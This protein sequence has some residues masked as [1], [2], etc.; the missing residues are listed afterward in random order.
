[1]IVIPLGIIKTMSIA[2]SA[3]LCRCEGHFQQRLLNILNNLQAERDRKSV[4]E[5]KKSI[6]PTELLDHYTDNSWSQH[7]YNRSLHTGW[8]IASTQTHSWLKKHLIPAGRLLSISRLLKVL[9]NRPDVSKFA[10]LDQLLRKVFDKRL[11]LLRFSNQWY[12]TDLEMA[13]NKR[14]KADSKHLLLPFFDGNHW[15]QCVAESRA[16]RA[17]DYCSKI[18]L[19]AW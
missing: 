6:R 10:Y 19:P 15:A 8:T 9:D 1:M 12:Q 3:H 2:V 5:K 16:K 4:E 14:I 17:I 18:L 11:K 13:S 7:R